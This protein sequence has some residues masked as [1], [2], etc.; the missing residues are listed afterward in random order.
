MGTMPPLLLA[1]P[2]A[3]PFVVYAI[4]A[5]ARRARYRSLASRLGA[6]H[7]SSGWFAPGKIK[8]DRFE[9]EA[10]RVGKSYR[11]EVRVAPRTAPGIFFLRREFFGDRPDWKFVSVPGSRRE[12]VFLW[13]IA[14]PR[15]VEPTRAQRESLQA[16]L[17]TCAPLSVVRDALAAAKIRRILIEDGSVSTTFGGIVSRFA[18]LQRAIHALRQLTPQAHPS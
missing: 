11:T 10:V 18:R 1:V 4:V 9:I 14:L 17:A 5:L 2:L 3:L 8:G 6:E 13:E 7:V 15:A 16:W 12:R